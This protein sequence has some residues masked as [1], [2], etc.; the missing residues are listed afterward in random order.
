ME[1][2]EKMTEEVVKEETEA[3][4]SD[5]P[6]DESLSEK[7]TFKLENFSGPLDLLL[8][9]IKKSKLDIE[10]VEIS[11]LTE[12]YLE[13]MKDIS[14]VDMEVA[15]EFIEYA[16][17]LIEIKS[18]KLLPKVQEQEEDEL[19]P[20]Y[21][22]KLR[23]REY[24]MFKEVNEKLKDLESNDKF[25]KQPEKEANKF[26]IIIKDMELESLLDAFVNVMHKVNK[27]EK[28]KE[29]K[30]I[31][32]EVFTV[33]QKIS[34]IKDTLISR[35][36]LK[37]SELFLESSSKDEVITTFMALLELIKMQVIRV[38]QDGIFTDIQI[39]KTGD[40]FNGELI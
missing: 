26:R 31:I 2:E 4:V 20:E 28:S 24:Q 18:K 22:L 3:V 37:F 27:I 15:S 38:N 19:D 12:Q 32:K 35:D 36:R 33:E 5:N 16:A 6:E 9:L 23:L 11:K 13:V 1:E 21:I 30:E 39:E 34:S 40:E 29:S 17:I 10:E 8:S 25:Y 14:T 7:L